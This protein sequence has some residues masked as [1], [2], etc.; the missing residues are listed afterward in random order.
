MDGLEPAISGLTGRR[1]DE[2]D[3]REFQ[4]SFYRFMGG[5]RRKSE[6]LLPRVHG[7]ARLGQGC[8]TASV[9]LRRWKISTALTIVSRFKPSALPLAIQAANSPSSPAS[10]TFAPQSN[11][12]APKAALPV[13]QFRPD[14]VDMMNNRAFATVKHSMSRVRWNFSKPA[15]LLES[16]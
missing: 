1:N 2:E 5:M 14:L 6:L 3:Q 7:H 13:G 9:S 10:L 11:L 15:Q 4:H 8:G 16:V 12:H